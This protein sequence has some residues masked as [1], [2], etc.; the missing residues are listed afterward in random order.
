MALD[1]ARVKV[2]YRGWTAKWDEWLSRESTRLAPLHSRVRDWRAFA[3]DDELQVGFPLA[4]KS[5][6]EWRNARVVDVERGED[7]KVARIQVS[8]DAGKALWMDAQDE[9]LCPPRTHRARNAMPPPVGG[10]KAAPSSA[11]SSSSSSNQR[12]EAEAL[13]PSQK[14]VRVIQT[15]Y[16]AQW[17]P[18]D[19]VDAI[20][21]VMDQHSAEVFLVMAP[22]KHRDMWL[23]SWMDKKKAALAMP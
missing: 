20:N 23:R 4:S 8:V 18:Q 2:H 13:T 22:G 1:A 15:S 7:G 10:G 17:T 6:P 11:D 19:V 9:L 16:A 12:D 21:V 14:A 5:Y 3:L